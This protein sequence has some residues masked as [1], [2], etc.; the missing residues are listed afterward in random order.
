MGYP[1]CS[2]FENALIAQPNLIPQFVVF[3]SYKMKIM[4]FHKSAERF[5]GIGDSVPAPRTVP[6][7]QRSLFH[8]HRKQQHQKAIN[9]CVFVCVVCT[10]CSKRC[11]MHPWK[12]E[13]NEIC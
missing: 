2:H 10:L 6:Y 9:V 8:H 4:I 5:Y 7:A 13:T 3:V 11:F 12:K 1:P